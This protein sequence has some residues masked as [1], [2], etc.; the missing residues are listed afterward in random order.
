[1]RALLVYASSAVVILLIR[2][3]MAYVDEATAEYD[4]RLTLFVKSK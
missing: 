2:V 4:P 3:V 1:M